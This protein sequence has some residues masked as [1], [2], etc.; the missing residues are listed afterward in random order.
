MRPPRISRRIPV[1]AAVPESRRRRDGQLFRL[2]AQ[3]IYRIGR[4]AR[5]GR[6]ASSW[7]ASTAI[8]TIALLLRLHGLGDKPFWL[9]EVASLHRATMPWPNVALEPLRNNQYPAYF[10]LLWLVAKF[11]TSQWLL[12]LP[13]AVFGAIN[14][15]LVC[16][17]GRE[18]DGRRTGIAAGLLLALS[19]FDVQYGQ[20]ARPYTL[21]ACLILAA[22][23]G[24]ARLAKEPS[25]AAYKL[26]RDGVPLSPWLAYCGGT[27]AALNVLNVAV[28]WFL[29]ANLAAV[30]IA[31]HAGGARAAFLRKW[32]Y[33][34]VL[35]IVAW[36]PSAAA[37]YILSGGGVLH[38]SKWAP[39]E[40]LATIWSSVAPVYLDRISAFI[41][42]NLMPAR[43]PGLAVVIAALAAYGAW[44]LRRHPGVLALVGC[45]AVVPLLSLMSVSLVTPVLVPRYIAWTAAPFY[46]LAGA[47]LGGFGRERFAVCATVLAAACLIN[48][49]PYYHDETKPRWDLAAA[50]L[51]RETQPGDVVLLNNWYS[52]YVLMAFADHSGLADHRL[53]LTWKPAAAARLVPHHDLWVLFGRTG[54]VAMPAPQDYLNSLSW[55]GQP[56]A[57]QQIGRYI[58]LWRFGASNARVVSCPMAPHCS[59]AEPSIAKRWDGEPV[60]KSP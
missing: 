49:R 8:A 44:R 53:S 6:L 17:I 5:I 29:A 20:E 16:A 23:W 54:Q 31:R 47:G 11:G 33:A 52:Y 60:S 22:L 21:A 36:L 27:A 28:P 41:T 42:F 2:L 45:A 50:R 14:A 30:V 48:L 55:L 18:I 15:G 4:S 12:R 7:S 38:A 34:Q 13:S 51:A 58:I 10:V 1:M 35:I 39:P 25:T 19:P 32:G 59:N 57:Q 43:V 37:V 40:T 56:V 3:A 46:V 24:I 9:D 26:G